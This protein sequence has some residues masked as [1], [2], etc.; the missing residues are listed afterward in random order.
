M[1]ITAGTRLGVYQIL[2]PLGA[3]GM[4]EVYRARDTRLHRDVALKVLPAAFAQDPDRLPRFK[5]E[6]QVL[7]SL[8]HPHIAQVHG[9]EDHQGVHALVMELV[10]GRTLAELIESAGRPEGRPLH[11]GTSSPPSGVHAGLSINDTLAIARQIADAL[12]VAHDHGIIHRDLKPANVKV[13]DDGVVKVLDF[14]L[15][16]AI[17]PAQGSGLPPSPKASAGQATAEGEIENSPTIT[18]P[19]ATAMGMI[20]GTA[21]YM[22][23]EQAKGHRVDKRAD[24]WAFGCVLYEMLTGKR[25]FE[26]TDVTDTLAAV[27]RSEPDWSALPAGL[28]PSVRQLVTG[29]LIKERKDR[30]RDLSTALYL[31][32]DKPAVTSSPIAPATTSRRRLLVPLVVTAVTALAIGGVA[33]VLVWRAFAG[34]EPRATR[35][36]SILV[37]ATGPISVTWSPGTALALSPDGQELAYVSVN[38]GAPLERSAQLRVRSLSSLTVRELPGTFLARQPFFSSDG[39]WIGFFTP[40]GELRKISLAGGNPVTITT[41]IEGAAWARGLWLESG[42]IVFGSP[43]TGGLH[44]VSADGGTPQ[45]LTK[46]NAER[47]AHHWPV[48]Y[49]PESQ[50]IVFF[51]GFGPGAGGRLEAVRLASGARTDIVESNGPGW[52]LPS[53]HLV[54]DQADT[55]LAAPFDPRTLALA[56]SAV[57]LSDS[58]RRRGRMQE[59]AVSA[60]GTFAYLPDVDPSQVAVGRVDRNGTFAAIDGIPGGIRPRLSPDGQRIA[61]M[62]LGPTHPSAF[63]RDLTRGTT[64]PLGRTESG[65]SPVWHPDGQSIAIR[66]SGGKPPGIYFRDADGGE[67]V[68]AEGPRNTTLHPE[69][70]SPDG[71]LLAFTRQ[72]SD[73]HTLWTVTTT[74]KPVVAP[75]VESSSPV[76]GA[77]FSPDGRHLAYMVN[78]SPDAE[79][80]LRGYPNGRDVLVA[81]GNGPRWSRDGR[82]LYFDTDTGMMAVQVGTGSE[83]PVLGVPA[84]VLNRRTAGP[85]GV[86]AEYLRSS[87]GGASFDVFPDGTLIVTRGPDPQALREIVL[88]ENWFAELERIAPTR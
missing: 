42:A 22:A 85:A 1:T 47:E 62:V 38:P 84:R 63:V 30:I 11:S 43:A 16:K 27:L 68:L 13:T 12:S 14:G 23:P 36:V 56:G 65:A 40:T 37:P 46:V 67:R 48:S 76:Y 74:G 58:V 19:A 64:M 81:K 3:G 2:Q 8:N 10:D 29:C 25:A 35:R 32:N 75:L 70:F 77:A 53:G 73:R 49:V 78:L 57:P 54:Y 4:G 61:V 34:P 39:R 59:M 45:P 88:V 5:R 6:A 52:A 69:S 83:T 50:A 66:R 20:L 17:E 26:G 86:A 44:Q 51:A 80:H 9:F 87:N 55:L 72:D 15:A 33:A 21:A 60:D 7:A 28:P 24:V 18:T 71:T 82:V 31:L 41:G 79:V